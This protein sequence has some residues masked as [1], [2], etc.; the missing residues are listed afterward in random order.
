MKAKKKLRKSRKFM[1]YVK[2]LY[3]KKSIS[4]KVAIKMIDDEINRLRN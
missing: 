1:N 2:K 3:F 4:Y